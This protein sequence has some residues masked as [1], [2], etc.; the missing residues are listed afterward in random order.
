MAEY[1]AEFNNLVC[2][3]PSVE[4]DDLMKAKRFH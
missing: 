2:F 3:V 4:N 1:E